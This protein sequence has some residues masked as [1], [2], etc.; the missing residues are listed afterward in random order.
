[1]DHFFDYL[2]VRLNGDK[3]EGRRLVINW[4]FPDV[5]QHYMSNLEHCALTSLAGRQSEVADATVTLER[6]VLNRL[7]LREPTFPDAARRGLLAVDGHAEPVAELFTLLDDFPLMFP[8]VL[9]NDA[10][11]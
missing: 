5:G 3:A 10:K 11:R 6:T 7:G 4:I 1:L 2:A 8:I 9:P